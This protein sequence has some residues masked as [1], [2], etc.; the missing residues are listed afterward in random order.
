[1]VLVRNHALGIQQIPRRQIAHKP[2][3]MAAHH[4]MPDPI[5]SLSNNNNAIID[6]DDNNEVD[7]IDPK[8]YFMT[9]AAEK[10]IGQKSGDTVWKTPSRP[11]LTRKGWTKQLLG[12]N[13][14][15]AV[16][17]MGTG[18]PGWPSKRRRNRRLFFHRSRTLGFVATDDGKLDS[19]ND[20]NKLPDRFVIKTC[21]RF[22]A[23]VT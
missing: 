2:Q 22:D 9:T 13:P 11:K 10:Q 6:A 3:N 4:K 5:G 18:R 23:P 12:E 21:C 16:P 15:G 20:K 8:S 19:G 17:A 1:M 7:E 14:P